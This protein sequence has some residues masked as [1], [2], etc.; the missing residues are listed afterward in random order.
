[1]AGPNIRLPGAGGDASPGGGGS[2]DPLAGIPL[3]AIV[4]PEARQKARKKLQQR[5]IQEGKPL[6]RAGEMAD[7][8]YVVQS[9]R[10]RMFVRDRLNQ[11]RVLQFVGP[12]EVLGEASFMADTP[13]VT[14]AEAVEASRVWR[15]ARAD[16]DET[17]GA[18]QQVLRYLAG[19]IA[20][21]QAQMNSRLATESAPEEARPERGYVT[22]VY[23]PRG[24]AGVTTLATTLGISL[25][26]RIP[27]DVVLL[28]LDVLFGH[29]TTNLLLQ[30]RGVLANV[31]PITLNQLDR[32]G[33]DYY[34]VTHASSLRV[35]PASQRAEEGELVSSEHVRAAVRAL[36]RH[37]SHVVLDLPHGFGDIALTGLEVA[38]R[39]YVLATPELTTLRDVVECRRI[40]SELLALPEDK[41]RY[42]LNHPHPYTG[43]PVADFAAATGLPWEEVPF[44]GDGPSQAALRGESLP[45]S[46]ASNPVARSAAKVAESV[47]KA[48]REMQALTGRR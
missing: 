8:L 27:D 6:F 44:G 13:H 12:G 28:D 14:H 1:M 41:M 20:Q 11:E 3:F 19:V 4:S 36:R 10:F 37:F 7:A 31:T 17:L 46:R 29:A 45:R 30:I 24:G 15:I 16:F 43:V 23:S 9:G 21:R 38:D 22:A 40:F 47:Q 33:L 39:V 48:A 42:L 26:E 35:F 2:K 34:L 32:R 5:T 25:A 18:Q